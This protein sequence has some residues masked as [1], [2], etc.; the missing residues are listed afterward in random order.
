MRYYVY[1]SD[2]KVDML[3]PQVP[4]AIQQK[5]AAKLGFDLKLL[6]GS[7]STE[8]STLDTRV[9]RLEAVEDYIR[10]LGDQA[11]WPG[12][13]PWIVGETMATSMDIGDH[14]V[15]FI[16]DERDSILAL[17]GSA[18]HLIG[19]T[20][21]H[22]TSLPFSHFPHLRRVLRD[23][24]EEGSVW[25]LTLPA[26]LL[27]QH[28]GQGVAEGFQAWV[29]IILALCERVNEPRQ[30]IQFLAKRL[31]SSETFKRHGVKRCHVTLASPLY[32]ALAQ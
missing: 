32:V 9:A 16:A 1:I 5:I 26:D 6:S 30:R 24:A 17:G 2:A 4:G 23:L 21:A 19:A 10:S 22:E 28:P 3:L 13:A 18:H 15:L 14:A 29:D 20:A 7:L 31:A 8:R 27:A 25:V 11:I 12:A